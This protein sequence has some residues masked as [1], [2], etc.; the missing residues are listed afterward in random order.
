MPRRAAPVDDFNLLRDGGVLIDNNST[1]RTNG[2]GMSGLFFYDQAASGVIYNPYIPPAPQASLHDMMRTYDRLF[3]LDMRYAFILAGAASMPVEHHTVVVRN[4]TLHGG[5]LTQN[6]VLR[7]HDAA[8]SNVVRRRFLMSEDGTA[9]HIHRGMLELVQALNLELK[10]FVVMGLHARVEAAESQVV[11][12]L[13]LSQHLDPRWDIRTTAIRLRRSDRIFT[14]FANA[15]G[16]HVR[17][18]NAMALG[19]GES[20]YARSMQFATRDRYLK[21]LRDWLKSM[22][23]ADLATH[24]AGIDGTDYVDQLNRM[25]I[26]EQSTTDC[27]QRTLMAR[28]PMLLQQGGASDGSNINPQQ[29]AGGGAIV[30]I[31]N[32]N[33]NPPQPA[34]AGAAPPPPAAAPVFPPRGPHL[35]APGPMQAPPIP[36]ALPPAPPPP[37]QP[38]PPP[39]LGQPH[40]TDAQLT[41]QADRII[42]AITAQITAFRDE[43]NVGLPAL[44]NHAHEFQTNA[45]LALR[46]LERMIANTNQSVLASMEQQ[47]RIEAG[48]NDLVTALNM[49]SALPAESPPPPQ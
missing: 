46:R 49:V 19:A 26:V 13:I 31:V 3:E 18:N 25:R 48:L 34:A 16:A 7:C 17:C 4:D 10:R 28:N 39:P 45:S 6:D 27:T 44:M 23:T 33:A 40:I 38:P 37:L 47:G 24:L 14:V 5:A 11:Q 35:P 36:Q 32:N 20:Q 21:D 43:M 29:D 22:G 42:A 1:A 8:W 9:A 30:T 41:A 15:V 2:T 12:T